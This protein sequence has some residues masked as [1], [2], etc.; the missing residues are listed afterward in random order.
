MLIFYWE[1]LN[2]TNIFYNIFGS[3]CH[4]LYWNAVPIQSIRKPWR[5]SME[6]G[7]SWRA[8]SIHSHCTSL[9]FQIKNGT[10]RWT[11]F[12]RFTIR[13]IPFSE[14][15]TNE[16]LDILFVSSKCFETYPWPQ[17]TLDYSVIWITL[18]AAR[19]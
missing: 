15:K 12:C 5:K 7:T 6:H 2:K 11:V 9:R 13:T 8:I 10:I 19:K 14:Q 18:Q 1:M 16:I 17:K 3:F 4:T